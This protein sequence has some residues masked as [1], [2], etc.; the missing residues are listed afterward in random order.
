MPIAAVPGRRV[1]APV[2]RSNRQTPLAEGF[3]DR[4]TEESEVLSGRDAGDVAE[5]LGLVGARSDA[6]QVAER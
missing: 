4:E 6:P 3:V 2:K 5:G 1:A